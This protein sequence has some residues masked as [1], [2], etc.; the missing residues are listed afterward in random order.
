MH[1]GCLA[2]NLIIR[3]MTTIVVQFLLS[4]HHNGSPLLLSLRL[5][6]LS[7]P[8]IH[9]QPS[10][11]I[12][13]RIRD[14]FDSICTNN[15]HMHRSPGTTVFL[16]QNLNAATIKSKT[17]LPADLRMLVVVVMN[18]FILRALSGCSIH[19]DSEISNTILGPL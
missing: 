2:A 3:K 8:L 7:A 19:D 15:N 13:K 18:R 9:Q 11:R 4:L 14:L 1:T 17:A 12:A 10:F 5:P 16:L 6:L